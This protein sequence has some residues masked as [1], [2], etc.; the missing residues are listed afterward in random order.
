MREG[1]NERSYF[2]RLIF[3]RDEA[4]AEESGTDEQQGSRLWN[5]G[6]DHG[7][8]KLAENGELIGRLSKRSDTVSPSKVAENGQLKVSTFESVF[9]SQR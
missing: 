7:G 8:R 3:P 4:K 9:V 2:E 6:W 1:P 5:R